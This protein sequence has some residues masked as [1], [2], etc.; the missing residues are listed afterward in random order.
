[1]AVGLEL[2]GRLVT[3]PEQLHEGSEQVPDIPEAEA[4]AV[5]DVQQ[6]SEPA[7]EE[8]ERAGLLDDSEGSKEVSSTG[9]TDNAIDFKVLLRVRRLCTSTPQKLVFHMDLLDR[10]EQEQATVCLNWLSH[11]RGSLGALFPLEQ[12]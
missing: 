1:M 3:V 5:I 12:P 7:E 2:S 6:E 9:G 4:Q 10:K 11:P 8:D